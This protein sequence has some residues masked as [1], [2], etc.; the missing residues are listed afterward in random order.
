MSNNPLYQEVFLQ[1]KKLIRDGEYEIGHFLPT[2][3]KLQQIF[4]ASRTTIRKAVALLAT[5]GLVEVKQGCGT[6][7]LDFRYTQNLSYVTSITE[8][9]RNKGYE[10]IIKSIFIDVIQADAKQ[11]K[12][13][14]IAENSDIYRIQRV[15]N[16]NGFP[17]TIMENY[18]DAKLAPNLESTV[19][20]TFSL[21]ETLEK[22]YNIHID[23]SLDTIG[24]K[25]AE[26]V[27]AQLLDIKVGAAL[28][29]IRRIELSGG[30][31][32]SYS[33]SLLRAD[34]YQLEISTSGRR[35]F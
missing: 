28:L 8:T 25:T 23:S 24:A 1:L 31:P 4:G 33:K 6:K 7:V 17:I 35:Y 9:L 32:V 30:K 13:L 34:R 3:E 21:Y 20:N 26:F 29:D 12:K 16:A 22:K 10:V 15:Q 5:E 11:A 27:E 2:E 14:G 19:S 18:I